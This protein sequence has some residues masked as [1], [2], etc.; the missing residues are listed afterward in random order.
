MAEKKSKPKPKRFDLQERLINFSVRII[1]VADALADIKTGN[2]IRGQLLHCGTSPPANY[3]EAQSAESRADF[4]HKIKIV[5][6]E[7]RETKVWL[8]LIMRASLINPTARLQPLI[9]ECDELI[10]I[11]VQSVK[12]ADSNRKQASTVR[13]AEKLK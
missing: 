7:L 4:I 8:L 5:L 6:K 11:F 12:T 1:Q 10:S 2:H 3:A 13:A 9:Q